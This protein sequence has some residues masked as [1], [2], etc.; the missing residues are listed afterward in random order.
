[1]DEWDRGMMESAFQAVNSVEGGWDFLK[2]YEPGEGGF[3]FGKHP[4]KMNEIDSAIM[5]RY[6]GHSGGSYGQTIRTIQYI[7]QNGWDTYVRIVG[8]KTPPAAP[9]SRTSVLDQSVA[10]DSFLHTL[11]SNATL[12]QFAD[13]IQNDPSMRNQIPDMDEQASALRQFADGKLTYSEMRRLCG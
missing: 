11:P 12:T 9:V 4:P 13:A 10:V 5:E 6:G 2:T 8:V 7:A 1:M 3:M